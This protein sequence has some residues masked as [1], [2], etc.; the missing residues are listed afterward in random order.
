[1]YNMAGDVLV[2]A[3]AA[4]AISRF[5]KGRLLMKRSYFVFLVT[6]V[7]LGPLALAQNKNPADP[8]LRPHHSNVIHPVLKGTPPHK[9]PAAV[10]HNTIGN[11]GAV[12]AKN[13]TD[14][15]LAALEHQQATPHNNPKPALKAAAPAMNGKAN[16]LGTNPPVNFA[17]KAPN[18]NNAI[19]GGVPNGR[20]QH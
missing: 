10:H 5:E 8:T 18:A 19:A 17:Y 1:M 4:H 9:D 13:G 3:A 11:A 6:I 12:P 2:L 20:K 16:N 7:S 15:Q 14:A